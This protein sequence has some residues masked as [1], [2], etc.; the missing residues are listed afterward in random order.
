[1]NYPTFLTS[2]V[3]PTKLSL[4][5]KGLLIAL[6]PLAISLFGLDEADLLQFIEQVTLLIAG[7]VTLWGL[8]R[9]WVGKNDSGVIE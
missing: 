1:M 9:K 7:A 2:S 3:D 6:V 8:V 4:T 5:V